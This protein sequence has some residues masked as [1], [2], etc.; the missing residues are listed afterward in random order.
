MNM[1][2]Q[3]IA[4]MTKPEIAVSPATAFKREQPAFDAV[5]R[6]ARISR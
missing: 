4:S 3:E 2:R 1:P 5:L 6:S